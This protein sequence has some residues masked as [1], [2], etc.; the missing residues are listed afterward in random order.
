MPSKPILRMAVALW[1]LHTYVYD[2]F[3]IT[4]RL[5]LM[6][7]VRGCG[8]TTL[9][10]LLDLLVANPYRTD[11]VTAAAIYHLLDRFPH[12]LLVDEADNLGLLQR[13][14]LSDA[15]VRRILRFG[16]LAPDLITKPGGVLLGPAAL[17][18]Y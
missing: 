2:R 7:P 1:I 3:T 12:A 9:L 17:N 8:K 18:R 13:F 11:N 15:H 4:P 14:R 5:A 16:Y 10:A 6:S